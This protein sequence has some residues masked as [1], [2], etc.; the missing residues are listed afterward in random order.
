M[1]IGYITWNFVNGPLMMCDGKKFSHITKEEKRIL[2][3]V[4]A[5]CSPTLFKTRRAAENAIKRTNEYAR[6]TWPDNMP[7]A[8]SAPIYIYPIEVKE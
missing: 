3:S 5:R 4:S 2:W 6:K 7:S 8:W 1:I